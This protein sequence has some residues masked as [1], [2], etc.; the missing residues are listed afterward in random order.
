MT[1]QIRATRNLPKTI[2][3]NKTNHIRHQMSSGCRIEL[4]LRTWDTQLPNPWNINIARILITTT[5]SSSSTVSVNVRHRTAHRQKLRFLLNI[6][7]RR[8]SIWQIDPS[9]GTT[10]DIWSPS[11]TIE[12]RLDSKIQIPQKYH[13][14]SNQLL[15]WISLPPQFAQ[16]NRHRLFSPWLP[17]IERQMDDFWERPTTMRMTMMLNRK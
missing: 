9:W 11:A 14:A 2:I 6:F 13:C 5:S 12:I 3:A 10:D 7:C 17:L 15:A 1:P 8:N 4:V 16:L